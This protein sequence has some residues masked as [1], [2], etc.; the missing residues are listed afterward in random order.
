MRTHLHLYLFASL[1][2]GSVALGQSVHVVDASGG[3][4]SDFTSLQVAV[5]FAQDGD[6]VLVREGVYD[7]TSVY[8]KGL[9]I[10][11]EEGASPLIV[12]TS[13]GFPALAFWGIPAG[14]TAQLR[15]LRLRGGPGLKVWGSDG[16]AF[17]DDCE[18]EGDCYVASDNPAI[19]VYESEVVVTNCELMGDDSCAI[20]VA[21]LVVRD[22]S[23]HVFDSFIDG[24]GVSADGVQ[25]HGDSFVYLS[26]SQLLGGDGSDAYGSGTSCVIGGDG[27][28]GIYV[29]ETPSGSPTV[30]TRDTSM[31]P[32]SAGAPAPDCPGGDHG[33]AIEAYGDVTVDELGTP[34]Y[35]LEANSPIRS[36]DDVELTIDGEP[37]DMALL[38]YSDALA[39]TFVPMLAASAAPATAPLLLAVAGVI[40]GDGELTVSSTLNLPPGIPFQHLVAQGVLVGATRVTLTAPRGV[41]VIDPAF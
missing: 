10:A 25:V 4:G 35:G 18:I 13:Y 41:T 38:L 23:A 20:V 8:S 29:I 36:G 21:G 14:S 34:A 7:A 28:A 1:A 9:T 31:W 16:P 32:G 30:V 12:A 26:G 27:G 33:Q 17:V 40:E 39:P 15:G 6:L 22:G 2:L 24:R 5:D 3:H 19:G 37:G 11:A